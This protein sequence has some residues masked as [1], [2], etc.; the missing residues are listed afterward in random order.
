V[1]SVPPRYQDDFN[2]VKPLSGFRN[3]LKKAY[4]YVAH[5][6]LQRPKR[7]R[8]RE[9]LYDIAAS[10]HPTSPSD[11]SPRPVVLDLAG[12]PQVNT[13]SLGPTIFLLKI[14]ETFATNR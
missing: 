6:N 11:Y 8:G 2:R 9:T 10:L 13:V 4:T 12:P 3:I 14:V 5:F 7:R 1:G